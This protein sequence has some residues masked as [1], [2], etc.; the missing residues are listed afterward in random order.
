MIA[1]VLRLPF[2]GLAT[3]I[4]RFKSDFL[5]RESRGT[6]LNASSMINLLC[7]RYRH[8]GSYLLHASATAILFALAG[9]LSGTSQKRATF[10]LLHL[11]PWLTTR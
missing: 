10:L 7:S 3:K 2:Q 6:R 5:G 9:S 8:R 1:G 4:R 11:V